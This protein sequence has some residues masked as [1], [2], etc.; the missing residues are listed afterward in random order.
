MPLRA[1]VGGE[2]IVGP[3]VPNEKWKDLVRSARS[4]AVEVR[5]PGCNSPGHPR[6]RKG[7]QHFAHNPGT[8]QV[9]TVHGAE[10]AAHLHAKWII[11][12]A[13]RQAGW[14]ADIEHAGQGW[15]ADVLAWQERSGIK[16]A[17]E[18]QWSRQTF[19]DYRTR[20]Q[21]YKDC[22]VRAAWF[23]RHTAHLQMNDSDVPIFELTRDDS[24]EFGVHLCG[25]TLP[26]P[27]VVTRLLTGQVKRREQLTSDHAQI[28][29]D[30]YDHPCYKC[31]CLCLVWNVQRVEVAGR[32]GQPYPYDLSRGSMWE[33]DRPEASREVRNAVTPVARD[34]DLPTAILS[35]RYSNTVRHRYM[36]FSCPHCHALF[37]DFPLRQDLAYRDP[38]EV[39]AVEGHVQVPY[40]HWCLN[41]GC[42]FCTPQP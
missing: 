20:Q 5:L 42:G 30:V 40:P 4:G 31:G 41:A 18:V 39:L 33:G 34:R 21:S 35:I 38:D 9:C 13:A 11:C 19:D 32:C 36:A 12:Q 10:S 24:D 15:I 8:G 27:E 6:I 17:L 26:L 22:G 2:L 23:A 7:L 1:E 3:Q 28:S 14:S 29:V 16:V 25:R 37:G